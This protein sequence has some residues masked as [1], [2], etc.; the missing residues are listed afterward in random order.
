MV[1]A[2]GK[3]GEARLVV[4]LDEYERGGRQYA[5]ATRSV[6]RIAHP[7]AMRWFNKSMDWN[8]ARISLPAESIIGF[9]LTSTLAA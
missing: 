5:L 8:V 7:E 9:T 1:R 2:S 3:D 6:S 4:T